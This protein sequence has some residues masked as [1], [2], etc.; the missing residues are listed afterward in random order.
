MCLEFARQ[1]LDVT[2]GDDLGAPHSIP[3][4]ISA[5]P[6]TSDRESLTT[7]RTSE[8]VAL[9]R[10]ASARR[11]V[12]IGGGVKGSSLAALLT[13][14]GEH[15]VLLVDRGN[16]G[17]GA[18]CTNHGRLHLGTAN[19]RREPLTRMRR[20][21][22]GSETWRLLP[23]ALESSESALYCFD[24]DHTGDEF[25]RKCEAAGICVRPATPAAI[26]SVRGWI[27]PLRFTSLFEVPEFSFSPARLAGRLALFAEQNGAKVLYDHAVT[28][29]TATKRSINVELASGVVER[30]DCVINMSARWS[31]SIH[32]QKKQG[33]VPVDWFQWPILCLRAK[34]L[35]PLPR[36][37]V[38]DANG[39][40]PTV[41]P[42]GDFI[43]LD[44]KTRA[45]EQVHSPDATSHEAW[46]RT[47]ITREL[48]GEVVRLAR[49]HFPAIDK[50]SSKKFHE[51]SYTFW[52]IQGRKRHD[53]PLRFTGG[54]ES[55]VY[56]FPLYERFL[57]VLGG[58]AS[59][60]LLDAAEVLD[61]MWQRGLCTKQ[62]RQDLLSRVAAGLPK[63]P[64]VGS[65]EMIW[66]T[67]EG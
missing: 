4:S 19:W 7:Q 58:Q 61:H 47:K 9:G 5:R 54:S 6:E 50:L 55:D 32:F 18:T 28:G 37:V 67:V 64:H 23:T 10:M 3:P 21:L 26:R 40:S 11:I 41:I 35:P 20:R 8:R 59:T 22:K 2:Y 17:S 12:V 36:I 25:Q 46:R 53:N 13:A 14:C 24:T 31:S 52:G 63:D 65:V 49:T 16:I 45:P 42:H 34:V 30:A 43:T 57:V 39:K 1:P 29:V 38:I 62:T 66:Q 48:E 44:A 56:T 15:D 27:D 60:G 51:S 33:V